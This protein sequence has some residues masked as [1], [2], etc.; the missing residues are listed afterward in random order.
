MS[1]LDF[2]GRK[3]F[4][5]CGATDM[6]KSFNSLADIVEGSFELDPLG[7]ALFV[8]CNRR[9]NR[10]KILEWNGDGYWLYMKELENTCFRWPDNSTEE[11]VMTISDTEMQALVDGPRLE[12]KIKRKTLFE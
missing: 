4:L 12:Q 7:D 8:F 6:R 9:K 10:M 2:S 1:C 5:A 11:M 3:I